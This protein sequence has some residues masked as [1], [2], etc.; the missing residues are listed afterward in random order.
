MLT[1]ILPLLVIRP[2][3]YSAKRHALIDLSAL[4]DLPYVLFG[5]GLLLGYMGI[6]VVFV[7]IQLYAVAT[8]GVP[9]ELAF[10]LLAIINAGSSLG[11]VIPNFSA[12]YIGTLNMQLLFVSVAAMLSLALLAIHATSGILAF[13]VLYGFFTGT[14]VSLPG[15]TVASMSPNLAF[16]SAGTGLLVG[17]P[18]GGAIL[19]TRGG[20]NWTML[21]VWSGAL[22]VL[23]TVCML[24]AR[25]K[26]VGWG[27]LRKA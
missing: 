16:M 19:A 20:D 6:Y 13:C 3:N 27:P 10:Y 11:R 1:L 21:Q 7:Y 17:T 4:R 26:K 22:L 25:V 12:D 8:A 9:S 18:I 15:P 2:L 14:F 5:C 23:S 24:G